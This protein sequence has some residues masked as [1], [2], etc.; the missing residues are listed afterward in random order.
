MYV[1]SRWYCCVIPASPERVC[2][3]SFI[4]RGAIAGAFADRMALLV[5]VYY[6]YLGAEMATTKMRISQVTPLD[7]FMLR[8][9]YSTPT[10][11]RPTT[12]YDT[13]STTTVGTRYRIK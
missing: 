6:I 2:I 8:R 10:D 4:S 7:F 3:D 5:G 12:H 1:G 13:T 11:S 9:I